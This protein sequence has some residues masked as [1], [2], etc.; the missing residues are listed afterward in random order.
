MGRIPRTMDGA[1]W[2][3]KADLNIETGPGLTAIFTIDLE[4]TAE[5]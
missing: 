2:K 4:E 1:V 3:D 5:S